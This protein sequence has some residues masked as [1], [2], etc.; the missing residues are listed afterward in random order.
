[1][2]KEKVDIMSI[3]GNFKRL[4]NTSEFRFKRN[5]LN[6]L[7]KT[8]KPYVKMVI[9]DFKN[10]IEYLED[11]IYYLNNLLNSYAKKIS[12]MRLKQS[13]IS[14]MIMMKI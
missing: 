14:L 6:N 13:D 4:A 12:L 1:M 9:N 7:K 3:N 10:D 8:L 2:I 5:L 11:C